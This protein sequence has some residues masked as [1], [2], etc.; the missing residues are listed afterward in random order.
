[1]KPKRHQ[2]EPT[3]QELRDCGFTEEALKYPLSENGVRALAHINGMSFEDYCKVSPAVWYA[4]NA[5]C[6]LKTE[7]RGAAHADGRL[8]KD[9]D[10]RW[11]ISAK[12]L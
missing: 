7:Q 11:I 4:P 3:V 2:P 6:Q 1:M 5:A 9:H 10:G 12:P 8:R